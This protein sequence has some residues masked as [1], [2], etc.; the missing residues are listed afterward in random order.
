M[1]TTSDFVLYHERKDCCEEAAHNVDGVKGIFV[2]RSYI[3]PLRTSA[4]GNGTA[5]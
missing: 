2:H 4:P 1:I 5:E 3:L